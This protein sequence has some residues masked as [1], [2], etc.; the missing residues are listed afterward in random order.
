MRLFTLIAII[1]PAF[2]CLPALANTAKVPA[3]TQLV[4]RGETEPNKTPCQ[5]NVI[6]SNLAQ[7]PASA[8]ITT[9]LSHDNEEPEIMLVTQKAERPQ[10]LLGVGENGK[11]EIAVLFSA[12]PSDWSQATGFN[13]KWWHR[14]HFDLLRCRKLRVVTP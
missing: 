14:N 6:E 11:D 13:F 4:L 10:M 2:V 12:V 3:G 5:L 9:S 7:S 1:T 8:R